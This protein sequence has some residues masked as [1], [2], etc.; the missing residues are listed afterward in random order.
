M[1]HFYTYINPE[2]IEAQFKKRVDDDDEEEEEDEDE[3]DED[4]RSQLETAEVEMVR[5]DSVHD[6]HESHNRYQTKM[7]MVWNVQDLYLSDV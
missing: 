6:H 1:A 2:E 5:R 4:N 3:E 7:W